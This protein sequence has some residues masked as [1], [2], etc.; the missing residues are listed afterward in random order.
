MDT[1]IP[2]LAYIVS[3]TLLYRISIVKNTDIRGN[4]DPCSGFRPRTPLEGVKHAMIER[5]SMEMR[6][7]I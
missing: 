1:K 4:C 7:T 6:I 3:I 5:K 2:P